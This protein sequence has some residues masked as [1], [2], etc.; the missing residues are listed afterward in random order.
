[1]ND[2]K[3]IEHPLKST[4]LQL[5]Q[6][7]SGLTRDQYSKPLEVLSNA[8][9][10]EHTRHVIEFFQTLLKGYETGYVNYDRRQ[11][12]YLL[13]TDQDVATMEIAF[14]QMNFEKKDKA[15]QLTGTYSK[16]SDQEVSVNTT[17]YRELIYNLEHLI[18]H[19]AVIKIGIR[20]STT[21]SVPA[22]FGV[23]SATIR[24]KKSIL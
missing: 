13:E 16:D 23:A 14:I 5:Q 7:L 1:M 17:Y 3:A 2:Y 12:N 4:L 19:M 20:D 8:S 15:I 9:I 6:V 22:E 10:G 24:H 11:R 21:V 18:H